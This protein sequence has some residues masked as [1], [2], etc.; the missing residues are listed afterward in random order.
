MDELKVRIFVNCE[1][2]PF[3][4]EDGL[5]GQSYMLDSSPFLVD[6][7]LETNISHFDGCIEHVQV[8][9]SHEGPARKAR[10]DPI[11]DTYRSLGRELGAVGDRRAFF[12]A[13]IILGAATR[14]HRIKIVSK[15][16]VKDR[17]RLLLAIS[18]VAPD[19][20]SAL[21]KKFPYAVRYLENTHVVERDTSGY[22]DATMHGDFDSA[23]K[24]AAFHILGT[25][26]Y[27]GMTERNPLGL[28]PDSVEPRDIPMSYEVEGRVC[29]LDHYV[30]RAPV[31]SIGIRCESVE[32]VAEPTFNPDVGKHGT[33]SSH[34]S[35]IM[36][37]DLEE[38]LGKQFE[39]EPY[40]YGEDG[41]D[42]ESL[43][44]YFEELEM[45]E[46][47]DEEM[48]VDGYEGDEG[49]IDYEC[50]DC[51][52]LTT[53]D[54]AAF[55]GEALK[56]IIGDFMERL[57]YSEKRM[58]GFDDGGFDCLKLAPPYNL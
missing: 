25:L 20:Y 23:D 47:G 6:A 43:N 24:A 13:G 56:V 4:I 16:S 58:I 34:E 49:D 44:D 21:A 48:D 10:V 29:S 8:C 22:W 11:K 31:V 55:D 30:S 54:E 3:G 53:I 17:A 37:Y 40:E 18:E 12:N 50:D 5:E 28:T 15:F 45:A 9:T 39:S 57:E 27:T 38:G 41:I 33:D 36:E 26:R 46:E 52:P 51:D 1:S 42:P 19:E 32:E 2:E 14:E 7:D 35:D